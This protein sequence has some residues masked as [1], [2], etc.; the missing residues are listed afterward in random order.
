MAL[1]QG[2]LN[3][4]AL[5]ETES[6]VPELESLSGSI[7][8]VGDAPEEV[9][10]P[11]AGKLTIVGEVNEFDY[12]GK[13]TIVGEAHQRNVDGKITIIGEANQ[14]NVD[15]FICIV[16]VITELPVQV[17]P[18]PIGSS[19][20]SGVLP[21]TGSAIFTRWEETTAKEILAHRFFDV[22]ETSR[23]NFDDNRK[24]WRLEMNV[25]GAK[26]AQVAAFFVSHVWAGEA[27]YFYDLQANGFQYDPTGVLTT[28]RYKVRFVDEG[29]PRVQMLPASAAST[30]GRFVIPFSIIEVE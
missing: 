7:T 1:N 5:N 6:A 22:H 3:E 27:F 17:G 20:A 15:G 11:S 9:L 26:Q 13:I 24:G 8:I 16:G 2:E 19:T 18:H 28:G 4:F 30:G 10:S 25:T 21:E 12:L 23:L 29:F 14:R